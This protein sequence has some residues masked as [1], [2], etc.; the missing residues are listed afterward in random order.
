MSQ[1]GRLYSVDLF[2]GIT[3]AGMLIVNNPGSWSHVYPPL[4]HAEWVGCT[5]TDLIFPFFLFIVGVV[6]PIALRK[7]VERGDSRLALFEKILTRSLII[8]GFGLF[9]ALFP[10]FNLKPEYAYLAPL[11]YGLLVIALVGLLLKEIGENLAGRSAPGTPLGLY[12]KWVAWSAML[13]MLVLGSFAYDMSNLRWPGVLQRIGI[14]YGVCATLYLFTSWRGQAVLAVV[15]ML[16]YWAWMSF[17]PMPDGSAPALEPGHNWAA[18]IDQQFLSGHMWSQTGTWDPEG[19]FSTLPAV[20]TCLLGMLLGR[21]LQSGE[22]L[23][24][25]LSFTWVAGLA[26]ILLGLIWSLHF[27]LIKGLWTSSYVLYTAGWA[28]LVFGLLFWISDIKG[29]RGW[30]NPWVA[31]GTN[32]LFAYL[33]S[34]MLAKVSGAVGWTGSDG[35]WMSA[36]GHVYHLFGNFLPAKAASL[37]TALFHL[38]LVWIPVSILYKYRIF[39]KV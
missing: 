9:L 30:A 6:L 38:V 29:W 37:A 34:G 39:I 16:F 35:D 17:I 11:H 18:W 8:V 28:C 23:Q 13:G 1:T 31:F 26:L 22:P 24:K 2:R 27:P 21:W 32:A 36:T 25:Q 15:L 33:L 7:R 12:S 19:L 3:I 14:V 10:D 4:L 5:P 20:A